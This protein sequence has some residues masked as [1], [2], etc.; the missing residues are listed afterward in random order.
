MAKRKGQYK[1][2]PHPGVVLYERALPKGGAEWYAKFRDSCA[3][4]QRYMSLRSFDLGTPAARRAWAI[5]KAKKLA[6]ERAAFAAT[7]RIRTETPI[8]K[9]VADYRKRREAELKETTL[10]TYRHGLDL[11]LA[12]AA[13]SGPAIL[14]DLARTHLP[15]LRHFILN[16]PRL[17][18]ARRSK[19]GAR[20]AGDGQRTP[21]T[22]NKDLR[23][24]KVMLTEFRRADLLPHLDSDSIADGL[25][26]LRVTVPAPTFLRAEQ[27]RKLLT[28][29]IRH[30]AARFAETREEHRT[31]QAI[32]ATPRHRPVAPLVLVTLL[33]G[34]RFSE[35]AELTWEEVDL[36][37]DGA[38]IL[39]AERVKTGRSRRIDLAISPSVKVL[40]A[41]LKL[42]AGADLYVFRGTAPLTTNERKAVLVRLREF[43]APRFT[44]QMLR[45]TCGTYLTCAPSI[46]GSASAFLSAKRLGHGVL[47]AEKH[48][49]GALTDISATAK[50]LEEAMGVTALAARIAAAVS[51]AEEG[52]TLARRASGT[53]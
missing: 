36:S 27:L 4:R 3:G 13:A 37:G 14:E 5:A 24:L 20:T 51:P 47:V 16:A 9:A 6:A 26:G 40:L 46:Y 33:T 35:A 32:G 18:V 2:S 50:T 22:V 43:G 10:A 19:R 15:G 53:D 44:F 41:A 31:R 45:R 8:A 11:F 25:R 38:I 12:W 21:M 34:M 29:A 1:R 48:Y 17:R 28:A 39:D 7:G 23:A 49:A 30:D 52:D 42:T